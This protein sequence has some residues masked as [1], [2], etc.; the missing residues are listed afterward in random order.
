MVRELELR[1]ADHGFGN[2]WP[3]ETLYLGGGTPSLLEPEALTYLVN[4]LLE[5][6]DVST[7][8]EFT[9]EANPEDVHPKNLELWKGLGVN[10]ISL[11]VQSVDDRFL[12]GMNRAH[13]SRQSL[14]A[15]R[16]LASDWSGPWTADLIYAYP[17]Q[18][19]ESLKKDLDTILSYQPGHFSAYQLTQEPRTV[20][21]TRVQR[22][23]VQMPEDDKALEL[24]HLLYQWAESQGYRA[25]EISNFAR[26]GCEAIHNSRYWSGQAYLGL[27]P[28]AHS[29]DGEQ[30]RSWN[31]SHNLHYCQGIEAGAPE[32][33]VEVL[34]MADRLNEFLM[35]R[36]RLDAGMPWDELTSRFGTDAKD[37]VRER[38]FLL[39][40]SWFR[41]EGFLGEAQPLRLS[42]SGRGLADYIASSLFDDIL[43]QTQGT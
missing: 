29:F 42:R 6:F 2:R 9:L 21:H 24:M 40:P 8:Q 35:I 34:S 12:E 31:I 23:D 37:R 36:L 41:E 33:S 39:S 10:R 26:T 30:T 14:E 5:K 19:P 22:G 15:M 7:L 1:L 38:L 18:D 11:G 17:D 4:G 32:E 27:G 28:S 20:L 16:L 43:D 3:L 13:D 25:Y